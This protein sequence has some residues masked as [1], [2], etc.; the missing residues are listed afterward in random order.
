MALV[1]VSMVLWV[2][3]EDPLAF[4]WGLGVGHCLQPLGPYGLVGSEGGLGAGLNGDGGRGFP[5]PGVG[6]AGGG[7]CLW[8][9]DDGALGDGNVDEGLD[10]VV[11]G[12]RLCRGGSRSAE[13]CWGCGGWRVLALVW[14]RIWV[15]VGL[16]LLPSYFMWFLGLCGVVLVMLLVLVVVVVLLR[17]VLLFG[18]QFCL[19]SGF[20]LES[21]SRLR[22]TSS[23]RSEGTGAGWGGFAACL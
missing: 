15:R 5:R 17:A 4:G 18:F 13:G 7:G 16:L 6:L 3:P 1:V 2:C 8:G 12:G 11:L 19:G 23:R 10:R 9:V 22:R 20:G 14:V 21:G